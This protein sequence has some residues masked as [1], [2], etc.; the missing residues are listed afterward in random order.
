MK[1]A[2]LVCLLFAV[3][4]FLLFGCDGPFCSGVVVKKHHEAESMYVTYIPMQVGK[5]LVMIPYWY[6]DD[7]DFAV[8]V[9]DNG[10]HR[11]YYVDKETYERWDVGEW[12]DVTKA[13]AVST[14]DSDEQ[15]A[16]ASAEDART[17]GGDA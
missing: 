14:Q 2:R 12:F 6:L 15:L 4:L 3:S 9:N 5:V 10:K 16:E 17:Y 7:E 8:T 11:T 1:T 13:A